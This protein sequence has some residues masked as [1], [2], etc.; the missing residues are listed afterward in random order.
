MKQAD[1]FAGE[2]TE[3][4]LVRDIV[5]GFTHCG[6]PAVLGPPV[7]HGGCVNQAIVCAVCGTGVGERSITTENLSEAEKVS[8][9][10]LS[11]TTQ[12]TPR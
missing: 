3:S 4:A 11:Q 5:K 12:G 9:L 10:E 2:T 1:L 6:V 7:D 8:V